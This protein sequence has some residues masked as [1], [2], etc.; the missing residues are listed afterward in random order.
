MFCFQLM[1]HQINLN[2]QNDAIFDGRNFKF[3]FELMRSLHDLLFE[4][5]MIDIQKFY[6]YLF[7]DFF[8][9]SISDFTFKIYKEGYFSI[10]HYYLL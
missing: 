9:K 2:L 7:K 10:I 5:L 8:S 3:F 6:N 4:W 1:I